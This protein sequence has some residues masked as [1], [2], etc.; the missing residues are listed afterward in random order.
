MGRSV[1]RIV[2]QDIEPPEPLAHAVEQ[3]RNAR[4]LAYVDG[5]SGHLAKPGIFL[6]E[7]PASLI[8]AVADGHAHPLPQQVADDAFADALRTTGNQRHAFF[9]FILHATPPDIFFSEN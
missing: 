8:V 9:L 5:K 1:S 4:F 2:D 7:F 6:T 3:G